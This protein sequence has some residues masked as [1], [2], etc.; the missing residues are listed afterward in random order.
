MLFLLYV[1]RWLTDRPAIRSSC[2][3]RALVNGAT[4]PP[5]LSLIHFGCP[6]STCFGNLCLIIYL[7]WT[8]WSTFRRR[9]IAY[10]LQTHRH[11]PPLTAIHLHRWVC[12][13]VQNHVPSHPYIIGW[14]ILSRD[15]SRILLSLYKC[16]CDGIS[17]L[18]FW[19]IVLECVCACG[20]VCVCQFILALYFG[21][22]LYMFVLKN[23]LYCSPPPPSFHSYS[24]DTC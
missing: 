5:A 24:Y 6:C 3:Y 13:L 22:A 7:I 1:V 9:I 18:Y 20:C 23:V 8:I 12:V 4:G 14:K 2:E 17:L 19:L 21:N 10:R 11:S 15:T 16:E